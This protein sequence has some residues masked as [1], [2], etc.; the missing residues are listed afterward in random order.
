MIAQLRKLSA[1]FRRLFANEQT[2]EQQDVEIDDEIRDHLQQLTDRFVAQGM[3]RT[4]AMAAARRQFGNLA[5]HHE[6]RHETRT[7]GRGR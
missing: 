3:S 5:V 4:D 1:K 7:I 6:D 2:R